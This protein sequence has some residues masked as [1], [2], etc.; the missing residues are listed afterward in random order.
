MHDSPR[1]SLL[2]TLV[3]VA[4]MALMVW[5]EMPE[6]QREMMTRAVRSRLHRVAAKLARASGRRAMGDELAGRASEAD[7]GYRR[8]YRLSVT[9]DR[10]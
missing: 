10:L 9:R 5:A 4:G 8:T 7:A 6:W 1:A 2:V 3:T